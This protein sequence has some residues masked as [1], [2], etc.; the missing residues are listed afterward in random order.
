MIS[1]ENMPIIQPIPIPTKDKGFFGALFIWL[2]KARQWTVMEDWCYTLR[3]IYMVIPKGFIFDGASVP[4]YFW[5]W[6]SPTGILLI[7][8]LIHDYGYKYGTL[9]K[10]DKKSTTGPQSLR[11]TDRLFL[12]VN[13]EVNGFKVINYLVFLGLRAGSWWAW[14][15]HRKANHKW[16]NS[17]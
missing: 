12:E 16:E 2:F 10:L 7:A 6:V 4:K 8:G 9:L 13:I 15:N 3:G 11:N 14:H 1:Y 5:S 17:V